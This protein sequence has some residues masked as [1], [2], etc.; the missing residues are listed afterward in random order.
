MKFSVE[1]V[2]VAHKN[3]CYSICLANLFM[4][5]QFLANHINVLGNELLTESQ[6][7]ELLVMSKNSCCS[8]ISLARNYLL[9]ERDYFEGLDKKQIL[10]TIGAE[11]PVF[12]IT[13]AVDNTNEDIGHRVLLFKH[14]DELV[15][16]DPSVK[17]PLLGRGEIEK[18]LIGKVIVD[19]STFI[20]SDISKVLQFKDEDL[21][22]ILEH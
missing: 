4:D 6:E 9:N 5:S 10:D 18:F 12:L 14:N 19:F 21:E 16:G 2:G 8:I 3:M 11:G 7:R 15:M 22:W 20:D 1:E 13:I 17:K